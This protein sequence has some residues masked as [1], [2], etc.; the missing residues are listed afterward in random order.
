MIK[1]YEVEFTSHKDA[2]EYFCYCMLGVRK[3][4]AKEAEAWFGE[5][6]GFYV[7]EVLEISQEEAYIDYEMDEYEKRPNRRV[8]GIGREAAHG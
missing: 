3:P 8:F 5:E 1:Y 7:S 6:A 2:D 4:T